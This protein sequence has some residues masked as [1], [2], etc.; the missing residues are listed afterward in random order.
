MTQQ[1]KFHIKYSTVIIFHSPSSH[2]CVCLI[3]NCM[4][5][6]GNPYY[7]KLEVGNIFYNLYQKIAA[8]VI[9]WKS[10]LCE[11]HVYA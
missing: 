2:Y 6:R 3:S 4:D 10:Q 5:L 1:T 8:K 11:V 7:K 9:K